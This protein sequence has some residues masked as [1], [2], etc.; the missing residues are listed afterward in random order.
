MARVNRRLNP[1]QIE[2]YMDKGKRIVDNQEI[3][4]GYLK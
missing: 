1:I 4:K 3:I 2:K